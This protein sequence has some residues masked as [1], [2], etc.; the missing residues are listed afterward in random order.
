MFIVLLLA[1]FM[2]DLWVLA[3]RPDSSDLDLV[4][5]STRHMDNRAC[6]LL[7]AQLGVVMGLI[8]GRNPGQLG[9]RLHRIFE[10]VGAVDMSG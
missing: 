7:C 2:P 8:M 9:G 6:A 3:D 1:L 5:G 4:P 10:T